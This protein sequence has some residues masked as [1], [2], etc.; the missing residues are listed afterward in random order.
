M[1]QLHFGLHTRQIREDDATTSA[2]GETDPDV[3]ARAAD[4]FRVFLSS[5]MPS[6]RTPQR[7]AVR[8]FAALWCLDPSAFAGKSQRDIAQEL[9]VNHQAFNRLA[10][11]W[12]KQFG[13]IGTKMRPRAKTINAARS[14]PRKKWVQ[15]V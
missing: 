1:P 7:F 6:D 11:K 10:A 14:L 13:F 5:L 9:G 15:G 3:T 4:A 2:H 8:G 12:S